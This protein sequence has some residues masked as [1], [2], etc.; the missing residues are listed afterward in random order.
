M[1][2]PLL[3]VAIACQLLACASHSV[4]QETKAQPNRV[5]FVFAFPDGHHEIFRME[6]DRAQKI[7][8]NTGAGDV[9]Q[10][11]GDVRLTMIPRPAYAVPRR[12]ASEDPGIPH[13]LVL[14][15]A[16]GV[17]YNEKTGQIHTQ[18]DVYIT[19]SDQGHKRD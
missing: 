7:V 12:S 14:L 1:R 15:H 3:C 16:D 11:R 10:L 19:F 18:G 17:D 9:L 4:C 6:A 8:S 5:H 2:L 13:S